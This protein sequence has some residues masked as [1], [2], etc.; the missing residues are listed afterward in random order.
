ME[1]PMDERRVNLLEMEGLTK[2]FPGVTALDH[3]DFA[4]PEHSVHVLVGENGAGKST[5]VNIVSGAYTPDHCDAYR[6]GGHD[7]H[8]HN[9]RQALELGITAVQQ[10]FSLVPD[11]PVAD[12]IF[13]NC[14]PRKRSGLID[15][16]KMYRDA[17]QIIEQLDVPINA[18]WPVRQL[19]AS[20]RQVVEI[21]KAISR[22]PRL[23]LMDEPTSGLN[24]AEIERLFVVVRRLVKSGLTILYISLRLEEVFEIGEGVTVLRNG[25]KV[26]EMELKDTSH[27]ELTHLI[28][29]FEIDDWFPKSEVAI[30][31]PLLT[32]ENLSNSN[33]SVPLHD[34]T[35]S[36]RCGEILGVYGILGSGKDDLAHT[37]FGMIPAT[38]GTISIDRNPVV[39]RDP[40]RANAEGL[41]YLTEDRSRNGYVPLMSVAKNQTLVALKNFCR[42][43]VIDYQKENRVSDEYIQRM[44]ISTPSRSTVIKS[45]SGGNQQKVLFSRWL[46][47]DARVLLLNEPTR[48]IDVGAK[49]EMF[50]LMCQEAEQGKA[51]CFFS[52]ELDEIVGMADRVLV[53]C[54]GRIEGEFHRGRMTKQDLL[55]CATAAKRDRQPAAHESNSTQGAQK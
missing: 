54:H 41:G 46:I 18:R 13:L 12:N 34:I 31:E 53:M 14:E 29:G 44:R 43:D 39:M 25:R 23:L 36:V 28:T 49:V 27:K 21:C 5:L 50:R 35:F 24:S 3:V 48:G 17:S 1:G 51:I 22:R 38:A 9:P 7:V 20:D 52:S 16:Q 42:F 47:A 40:A 15:Y 55:V 37:L 19:S 4:I 45:L 10:H 32:V 2:T 11:M 30:G 26:A 8:L 33:T 6:F